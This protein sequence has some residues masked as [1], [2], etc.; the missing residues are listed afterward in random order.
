MIVESI[1]SPS[2]KT[3]ANKF[4]CAK[5]QPSEKLHAVH[6]NLFFLIYELIYLDAGILLI[7]RLLY[8]P[9]ILRISTNDVV[10]NEADVDNKN[11]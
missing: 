3:E 4:R 2:D 7:I 9:Y 10:V 6:N 8:I 11:W 1:I 5:R